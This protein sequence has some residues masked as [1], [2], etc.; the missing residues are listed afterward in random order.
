MKKTG[1]GTAG[2]LSREKKQHTARH[3]NVP[4]EPELFCAENFPHPGRCDEYA[5]G[6]KEG[7]EE[8]LPLR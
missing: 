3:K 7:N 5:G 1:R 4:A 2:G 6:R 8:G